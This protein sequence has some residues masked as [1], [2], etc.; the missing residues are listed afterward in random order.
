MT[1]LV[2]VVLICENK[3]VSRVRFPTQQQEAEMTEVRYFLSTT[4]TK[5]FCLANPRL[6]PVQNSCFRYIGTFQTDK[7]KTPMGLRHRQH[8]DWCN[9]AQIGF[10]SPKKKCETWTGYYYEIYGGDA[11]ECVM[12]FRNV[13]IKQLKLQCTTNGS[14][15]KR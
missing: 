13:I 4:K 10:V 5:T 12:A 14:S 9:K 7:Q 3:K 1:R 6:S 8:F 11:D 2:T 15:A